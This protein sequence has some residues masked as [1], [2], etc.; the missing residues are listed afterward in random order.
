MSKFSD[1]LQELLELQ[2]RLKKVTNRLWSIRLC[3]SDVQD[4]DRMQ[5]FLRR[6]LSMRQHEEQIKFERLLNQL[7]RLISLHLD[8]SLFAFS[9]ID[10]VNAMREISTMIRYLHNA[11]AGELSVGKTWAKLN[12][13]LPAFSIN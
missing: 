6:R 4:D 7:N 2:D 3:L 10:D 9:S 8:S 1:I 5:E 12:A 13:A 11:F